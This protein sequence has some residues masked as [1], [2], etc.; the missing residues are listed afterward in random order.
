MPQKVLCSYSYYLNLGPLFKL[1][2]F[3]N[4]KS[5]IK[6]AIKHNELD[7]INCCYTIGGHAVNA[8]EG[9]RIILDKMGPA[10]NYPKNSI[11]TLA[12]RSVIS[13]KDRELMEEET[14]M[15]DKYYKDYYKSGS[16][17]GSVNSRSSST[18]SKNGKKQYLEPGV[19]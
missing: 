19:I 9:E 6:K 10:S 14:K 4:Q 17:K 5:I 12:A 13:K 2:K 8:A 15:L 11:L 3:S 16:K 18:E 7:E 1:K